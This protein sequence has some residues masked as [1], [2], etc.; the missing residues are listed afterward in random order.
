M[1]VAR[2][3]YMTRP[4]SKTEKPESKEE[5]MG[6]SI[7]LELRGH[8]PV[9]SHSGDWLFRFPNVL[10]WCVSDSENNYQLRLKM[11]MET[12]SSL[13]CA[14]A[15]RVSQDGAEDS[16]SVQSFLDAIS[17]HNNTW[18]RNNLTDEVKATQSLRN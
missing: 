15:M 8:A 1:F 2:I 12:Y 18:C 6:R 10:N 9:Q 7:G 14:L 13:L 3:D 11:S 4:G 16:V 5:G 17:F